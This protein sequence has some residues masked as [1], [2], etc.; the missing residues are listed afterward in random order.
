MN[1]STAPSTSVSAAPATEVALNGLPERPLETDAEL[2]A[3]FEELAARVAASGATVV[4]EK[5]YAPLAEHPRLEGLREAAWRHCGLD[6]DS[7]R[8]FVEGHPCL[9]GRLAGVQIVAVT[10]G[11]VQDVRRD[12]RCVGRLVDGRTL[13]ASGVQGGSGDVASQTRRMFEDAFDLMAEHGFPASSLVRTWIYN[14]RILDWYGEFN[15][16]RTEVFRECGLLG[17]L[18]ASTGIQGRGPAGSETMMDILAVSGPARPMTN[19][20]QNEAPDY[21]S[22]FSRGM[23]VDRMLSLSGTASID[24]TGRTVRFDD[25]VGQVMETLVNLA[26]LLE[27][28]GATLQDL[29]SATLFCKT[30]EVW[31]AWNE[32]TRLLQ[33]PPLP[34][35]AVYADVCRHE[36]LVE[37]EGLAIR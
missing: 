15:R 23:V 10:D 12:G 5:L 14:A 26:S 29:V 11:Q 28:E 32:L 37:I 22:S 35:V 24:T 3:F 2:L 20:R 25:P 36:L 4:Q 16:A 6:P 13:W 18:P 19:R 9:G 31:H 27:S 8:L 21:G 7:P 17:R 33:M 30:P 34:V 1:P